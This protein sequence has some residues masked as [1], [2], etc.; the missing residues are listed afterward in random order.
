LCYE[1]NVKNPKR[2]TEEDLR[3]LDLAFI[4]ELRTA[5]LE[6]LQMIALNLSFGGPEWQRE[7]VRRAIKRKGL[8][9]L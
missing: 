7:A 2:L 8:G 4:R 6:R 1:L 5:S 9:H 3:R